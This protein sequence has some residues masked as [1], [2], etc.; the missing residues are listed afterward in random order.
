MNIFGILTLVGVG[1]A[2]AMIAIFLVMYLV[3]LRRIA[4]VLGAVSGAVQGISIQVKP[5][6]PILTNVNHNLATARDALA[7]VF[8]R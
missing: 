1:I 8:A 3:E 6:E 2:L 5:L 7:G 4:R